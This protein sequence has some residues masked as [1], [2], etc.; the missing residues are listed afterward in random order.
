[1]KDTV[2][3]RVSR[4]CHAQ[5]QEYANANKITLTLALDM[6]CKKFLSCGIDLRTMLSVARDS[7]DEAIDKLMAEPLK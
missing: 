4:K 3:V 5:M 1:M 7:Y 6:A 2:P